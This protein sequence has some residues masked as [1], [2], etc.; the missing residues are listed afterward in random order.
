VSKG[1]R[2]KQAA[3]ERIA[4]MRA[5]QARRRRRRI[6]VASSAAAAVVV[7]VVAGIILAVTGGGSGA[8]TGAAP[9]LSLAPLSTLGALQPAPAAGAAGPEGVPVPAVAPLARTA[10]AATG[11]PVD[12]ISCQTGEQTLFHI[13]AHLA[14]FVD[15]QARRVPA[16]IGIPG[17]Q[18]QETPNGPFI[19]AG[20]CFYWLHTHAPDGIIHIESPVH[21]TY[22]LGEFFDEWGQPLGPDR[23]GP[24]AGRVVALYNG[25]VY[26]GNPRDIPLTAHAQIQLDIGTPLI[27]PQPISFPAGL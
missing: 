1:S 25:K 17:P 14:I 27:A 20:T 24:A 6:R 9:G 4:R 19:A 15:G 3:R 16:A 26:Q 7:A 8:T 2:N 12:Q 21:R 10:T 11:R 22:T 18:A 5:E 23:V 13:H